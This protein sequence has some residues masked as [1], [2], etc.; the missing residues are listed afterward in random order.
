MSVT[1]VGDIRVSVMRSVLM[2]FLGSLIPGEA[3]SMVTRL[4]T[5]VKML[6]DAQFSRHSH[7]LSVPFSQFL[8]ITPDEGVRRKPIPQFIYLNMHFFLL[9]FPKHSCQNAHGLL[10]ISQI[11]HGAHQ[12]MVSDTV[13]S[14]FAVLKI[15]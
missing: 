5:C 2:L 4:A 9:P 6:P 10:I 11:A 15:L 3:V 13:S 1:G 12:V 8:N 14:V 7:F